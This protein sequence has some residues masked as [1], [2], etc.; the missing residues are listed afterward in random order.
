MAPV[1]G[2]YIA[3]TFYRV[4]PAWRR[5]PIEERAAG[6]DAFADVVDD[7]ADRMDVLRAYSV[8]G[9]R[10]DCDFF[11]WK[12]TTRYD[13]LAD[14]GAALNSMVEDLAGLAAVAGRVA[15]GDLSQSVH[16]RSERDVLGSAF[17]AMLVNLN[18]LVG[19]VHRATRTLADVSRE[20]AESSG[21]ADRT[22]GEIARAI[23][24]VANG[25]EE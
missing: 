11:L 16:V 15:E 24:E 2:Q 12:I 1:D 7:W 9:V 8:A 4:D 21:E 22:M 23:D 6:K 18:G 25:T 13:D 14:L 19:E 17:A 10:P 20:I 3:Y 5:L